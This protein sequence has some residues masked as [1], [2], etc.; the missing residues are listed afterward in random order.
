M[1]PRQ[2]LAVGALI[3]LFVAP[4]FMGPP[5]Y[6][7]LGRLLFGWWSY[8]ARVVPRATISRDGVG[9][10]LV[11]L[12]LFTAGL[13]RFL[14]WIQG[15]VRR[16]A[17]PAGRAA[18]RW[19]FR[20]TASIVAVVVLM[21][22]A[23]ISAAGVVHQAGWL[24]S[25]R[26]PLA[27][28]RPVAGGGAYRSSTVRLKQISLAMHDY[29]SANDDSL[30]PAMSDA[31]GRPLHSWQTALLHYL[32]AM[33]G[34]IRMDLPWDDPRNSAHFRGIVPDYLHPEIGV[35]RDDRGYA[36]S[37]YAGN[38]RLLGVARPPR[39]EDLPGGTS[40]TILAGEVS[41]GFKPWGD[42]SNLRDPARGIRHAAD[43]FCGPSG[44]GANILF[45]DGSVRFLR[46]TTPSD[47]RRASGV[48]ERRAE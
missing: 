2:R 31:R 10:G 32:P 24:L 3:A 48:P 33:A 22:V 28:L 34:E 18:R 29:L 17:D 23:G 42:P 40:G 21:F 30:P 38:V 25:S 43:A 27:V 39:L 7:V 20:R 46:G 16:A 6:E 8:L 4:A 19:P 44:G 26:R 41:A 13:H 12:I 36:L 14:R 37:H 45:L 5:G 11:C 9:T 47:I 15:E 1:K 35:V